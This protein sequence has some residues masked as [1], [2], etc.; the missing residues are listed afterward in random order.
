[1]FAAPIEEGV[2]DATFV[3]QERVEGLFQNAATK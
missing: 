1:V 2:D 3:G